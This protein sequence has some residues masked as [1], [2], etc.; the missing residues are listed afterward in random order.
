MGF[1]WNRM[2][3]AVLGRDEPCKLARPRARANELD[4]WCSQTLRPSQTTSDV[5]VIEHEGLSLIWLG[6]D[7]RRSHHLWSIQFFFLVQC[8][9]HGTSR[10]WTSPRPVQPALFVLDLIVS[11]LYDHQSDPEI[12]ML[13]QILHILQMDVYDRRGS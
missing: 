5:A 3:G 6:E 1:F 2:K 7:M 11:L 13:F 9:T 8:S 12:E 10:L 4:Y